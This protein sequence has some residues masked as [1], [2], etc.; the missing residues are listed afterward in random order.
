MENFVQILILT[1][2]ELEIIQ[3]YYLGHYTH[4]SLESCFYYLLAIL[5]VFHSLSCL[6]IQ[7][8]LIFIFGAICKVEKFLNQLNT[9][10]TIF[11][12]NSLKS[13]FM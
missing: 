12:P 13:Y 6:T 11:F 10:E 8:S 2:D 3:L 5:P 1:Q 7:F 9:S 4:L